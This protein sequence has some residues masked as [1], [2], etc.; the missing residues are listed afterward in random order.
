[1]GSLFEIAKPIAKF[2]IGFDNLPQ[3]IINSSIL[4]GNEL[5]MLASVES[6]PTEK[7]KDS[8]T[9]KTEEKHILAKKLLEKGEI[10]EAWKI[11]I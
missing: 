2:G 8:I 11:L 9:L 4:T 1:M 10:I 6:I 3:D 7:N 5:A